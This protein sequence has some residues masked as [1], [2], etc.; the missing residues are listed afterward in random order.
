MEEKRIEE[1]MKKFNEIEER[2]VNCNN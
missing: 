2:K 1:E